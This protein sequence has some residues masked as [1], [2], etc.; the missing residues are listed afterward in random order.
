[1][2]T[3]TVSQ[4][5]GSFTILLQEAR[6]SNTTG[7]L[8]LHLAIVQHG[9]ACDRTVV[10]A[11]I[12]SYPEAA[13]VPTPIGYAISGQLCVTVDKRHIAVVG[14]LGCNTNITPDKKLVTLRRGPSKLEGAS[15]CRLSRGHVYCIDSVYHDGRVTCNDM[16]GK[17]RPSCKPP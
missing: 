10:E 9:P 3:P 5:T 11:L 13:A 15:G 7:L 17:G 4:H 16:A 6:M 14:A 2:H 8:P 12:A 1:M